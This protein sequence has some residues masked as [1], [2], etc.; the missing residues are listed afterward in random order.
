M[1]LHRVKWGRRL[2]EAA[3]WARITN[4]YHA[5]I[6]R[7]PVERVS[8]LGEECDGDESLRKQVEAMVRSHELSGDFI[9]LPAFA[10]APEL[11]VHEPAGALIG[12]SIG[13]YQIQSLLGAGG[14]GEVYLACDERLTRK[15]ALKLLPEHLTAD[16]IALSRFKSEARAASALNHPNI[17]TVYEIGADGNREFIATEFIDGVTL[18]TLL[19]RERMNL[20]DVL[21]VAIQ[22][23]SALAAAHKAG[24]IHRDIKPG[25]I[26]LRQD[27]YVKVLDF[28]IAKLAQAEPAASL[29]NEQRLLATQT[30]FGSTMGTL[31]YM[32]PEQT[33]G[34]AVDERTDI[35]SFGVVL[36][37]MVA[38]VTPFSGKTPEEI[39]QAIQQVTSAPAV[40]PGDLV[41]AELQE[42][43]SKALEKNCERR[44]AHI[45]EMLESL[46]QLRR[47]LDLPRESSGN[48]WLTSPKRAAAAAA[49]IVLAGAAVVFTLIHSHALRPATSAPK[50]IAVLPLDDRGASES[51]RYFADGIQHELIRQLSRIEDLKVIS[52]GSTQRY[53][54]SKRNLAEIARQLG[55]TYLLEGSVERI[56]KQIRLETH[57]SNAPTQAQLWTAT[58]DR[59][60]TDIFAVE[61]EIT[62]NVAGTLKIRVSGDDAHAFASTPTQ[63]SEAHE[64][65]LRG[66]YL[67][68]KRDEQDVKKAID[69]YEQAIEKDPIYALGY[70]GLAEAYVLLAAWGNETPIQQCYAIAK[71][72]AQKSVAIDTTLPEAHIGLAFAVLNQARDFRRA[73]EELERAIELAPNSATA[74]YYLGYLV[75]AA[76]GDL[77]H[78]IPEMKRAVELDPLSPI[79][80]AN[81][82]LCYLLARRYP[83]GLAQLVKTVKSDPTAFF[84]YDGLGWA[85]ALNG[86]LDEAIETWKHAYSIGHHYHS[87]AELAYGYAIKGDREQALKV[88]AQLRDLEQHGTRVW[89]LGHAYIELALGNKQEAIAWLERGAAEND[90][91][92]LNYIKTL[93][94]LDPLRGDPRFERLV[95]E[96]VPPKGGG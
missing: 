57:L 53:Q 20:H 17:L 26:M 8:F 71:T 76:E 30:N 91:A 36:Y 51:D 15:V 23:G 95:N 70:A 46:K 82:G 54:H 34:E 74:H 38:G 45:D 29:P 79:V 63:S 65:Y 7:P 94:P 73:R 1:A 48:N 11:L 72:A 42:I 59:P 12:R 13:C 90:S 62:T 88:V 21:E 27:G 61:S 39:I 32:S 50:S 77:D 75:Y 47:K 68:G 86:R 33:R 92:I 18:H 6:A 37:E 84:V 87:L 35:W 16:E 24:V 9:E 78:A 67:V 14:M 85:L 64:L 25:N 3:R 10:V 43:I 58:Y 81:F 31:R 60:L 2:M 40:G 83:E 22:A 96:I 28:G 69:F 66:H 56:G 4:I 89:A 49:F 44:F 80:N 55:V 19:A 93:P 41:P 52:Q 5:A